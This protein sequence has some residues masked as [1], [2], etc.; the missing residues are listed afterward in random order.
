MTHTV[1]GFGAGG[2][3]KVVIE[4]LR[5]FDEYKIYGLL[6]A[7]RS[8][9]GESVLGVTVLGGDTLVPELLTK[10]ID[11]F[12][13]GVGAISSLDPRRRLYETACEYGLNPTSAIHPTAI[14]SDT[15]T[16]GA[17]F[18]SMANTVINAQ[19]TIGDNVVVNTG[20]IVEHDCIVGSHVHISPRAVLLGAVTVGN[21]TMIGAGAII[22]QGIEIGSR[23]VIGAGAV[24]VKNV[25]DGEVVVGN[26]AKP[27]MRVK[28]R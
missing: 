5:C 24:V 11:S 23:A 12:F 20:A 4:I 2:N 1:I 6:D 7:N 17:G 15:A 28:S 16:I 3:A 25:P 18:T 26:P 10:G 13:I 14:L 21:S 22:R 27:I 9:W 19:A 8:L